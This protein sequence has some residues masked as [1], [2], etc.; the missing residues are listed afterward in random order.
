[1][2]L[3]FRL[4]SVFVVAIVKRYVQH[5]A[6]TQIIAI[7]VFKLNW[8]TATLLRSNRDKRYLTISLADNKM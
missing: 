1:M 5:V 3:M 4:E 8:I 6:N 2:Y 7:Y